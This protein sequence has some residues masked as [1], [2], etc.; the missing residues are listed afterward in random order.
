MYD[1]FTDRAR[2]VMQLANQEA[3]RWNHEYIGC[4]HVF[5][6]LIKEGSGVACRVLDELG[7]DAC[8][9][10]AAIESLMRNGPERVTMGKLPQTPT[11]KQAIECA[12]ESARNLGD[13]HVGTEHV[14]IGLLHNDMIS[15][16]VKVSAGEVVEKLKSIR[17]EEGREANEE[18]CVLKAVVSKETVVDIAKQLSAAELLELAQYKL[19]NMKG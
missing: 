18:F 17:G 12:I 19:R 13:N 14:L 8:K 2:K 7:V 16:A 5:L 9:S 4:E 15:S 1:K 3:Q 10:K 11:C 6:G